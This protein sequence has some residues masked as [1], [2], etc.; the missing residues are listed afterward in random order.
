M[1]IV[2]VTTIAQAD[3]AVN[4]FT[5]YGFTDVSNGADA[6]FLNT[7]ETALIQLINAGANATA[8]AVTDAGAG[9]FG[10]DI[11]ITSFTYT[12]SATPAAD[13]T[14]YAYDE[15]RS[16]TGSFSGGANIFARIY[17]DSTASVGSLY[18]DGAIVAAADSNPPTGTP[19]APTAYNFGGNTGTDVADFATVIPEPATIGLLGI[20]AAGLFTARRKVRV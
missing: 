19:P 7:G 2:A 14:G 6:L 4:Y 15:G 20:A 16:L 13:F 1:A 12:A 8:D 10:D 5:A 18:Y 11:L 3:V 9:M 17:Q